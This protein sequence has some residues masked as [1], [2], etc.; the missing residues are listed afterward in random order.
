MS[1]ISDQDIILNT[2]DLLKRLAVDPRLEGQAHV[3]VSIGAN[4]HGKT[5]LINVE[6]IPFEDINRPFA[7]LALFTSRGKNQLVGHLSYASDDKPDG[8]TVRPKT[9]Q[10]IADWIEMLLT[11]Y[12]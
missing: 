6:I 1:Q 8:E 10:E 2:L 12:A 11:L 3:E 9:F 4:G 5:P 7:E